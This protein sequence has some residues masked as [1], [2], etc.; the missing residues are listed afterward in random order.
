V[1]DFNKDVNMKRFYS[2][3]RGATLIISLVMLVI[4]TLLGISGIRNST[5]E[6]RMAANVEDRSRAFQAA[7]YTLRIAQAKV[8][9]LVDNGTYTSVF[10]GSD[11]PWYYKTLY[12]SSG[13]N[14]K[15][16][17]S[18]CSTNLP[19][20]SGTAKWDSS[21]SLALTS[22]EAAGIKDLN[23][24]ATPRF[25]IGYDTEN[26]ETSPCFADVSVEGYSNSLGSAGEPLKVERFT[27]TVIGYGSQPNT[28]VRL[29]ATYNA[30]L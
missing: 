14:G 15:G 12:I 25:M 17:S 23:L 13:S 1:G 4:L 29:Q 5:L 19:W 11:T 2:A 16:G 26:D 9:Q 18:S 30:L 3:S 10:G 7:E 28:R 22:E 8:F 21:D 27:I 20:L 6:I 24:D